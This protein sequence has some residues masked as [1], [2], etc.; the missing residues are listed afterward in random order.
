MAHFGVALGAITVTVIGG[1]LLLN[2]TSKPSENMA[3]LAPPAAVTGSGTPTPV[4]VASP[5]GGRE[6]EVITGARTAV[7]EASSPSAVSAPPPETSA[8]KARAPS[9]A[10]ASKSKTSPSNNGADLRSAV[11][12]TANTDM[13]KTDDTAP[14]TSSPSPAVD[15]MP[16]DKPSGD[17]PPKKEPDA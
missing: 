11:S 15:T 6:S 10:I 9:K 13:Q 3:S 14:P 8:G 5:N 1:A 4:G 7:D 2:H 17:Q 16:P 12:T